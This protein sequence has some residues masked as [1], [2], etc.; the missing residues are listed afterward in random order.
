MVMHI[1]AVRRRQVVL[2]RIERYNPANAGLLGR[3]LLQL[4]LAERIFGLIVAT[5]VTKRL[6]SNGSRIRSRDN[7]GFILFHGHEESIANR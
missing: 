3:Q 1:K 4:F 6:A 7:R 5:V 2:E